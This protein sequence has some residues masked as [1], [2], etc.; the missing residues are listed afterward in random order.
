M[1]GFRADGRLVTGSRDQTARIW[2]WKSPARNRIRF[3]GNNTPIAD[4]AFAPDGRIVSVEQDPNA[5]RWTRIV[6]W[7]PRNARAPDHA[8]PEPVVDAWTL[9]RVHEGLVAIGGVQNAGGFGTRE[10]QR[11]RPPSCV[12]TRNRSAMAFTN[13]QRLVTGS[14]DET[15]CVWN[16]KST[17]EPPVVIKHEPEIAGMVMGPN[18]ILATRCKG[19]KKVWVWDL[20]NPSLLPTVLL[21]F[22]NE[23]GCLFAF[24]A[25]GRLVTASQDRSVWVWDVKTRPNPFASASLPTGQSHGPGT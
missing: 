14:L 20:N 1:P 9:A 24:T 15:M 5:D 4:L 19:Q 16:L 2:N 11:N 10:T 7:D 18:G 3:E 8:L 6:I 13:D 21:G 22:Q 25:D 12:G 23:S 17:A